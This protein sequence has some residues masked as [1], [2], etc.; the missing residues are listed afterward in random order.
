MKWLAFS[1]QQAPIAVATALG[2]QDAEHATWPDVPVRQ[3]ICVLYSTEG[4]ACWLHHLLTASAST[5]AT[6]QV[7]ID[8]VLLRLQ[9]AE[10]FAADE[11]GRAEVAHAAGMQWARQEVAAPLGLENDASMEKIVVGV[12]VGGEGSGRVVVCCHYA[13]AGRCTACLGRIQSK[14]MATGKE[15]TA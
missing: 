12:V 2:A 8:D 15:Q 13:P 10:A 4:C 1:Y 3:C 9:Q 11:P 5:S 7:I 14:A 6:P